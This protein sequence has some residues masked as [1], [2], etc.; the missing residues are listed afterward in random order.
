MYNELAYYPLAYS[1]PSFIH[2][3]IL[4]ALGLNTEGT[5]GDGGMLDFPI[6]E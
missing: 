5:E 4:D 3:L 1:G 2:Q 6:P